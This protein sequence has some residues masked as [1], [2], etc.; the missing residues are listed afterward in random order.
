MNDAGS[1][2][3]C[4]SPAPHGFDSGTVPDECTVWEWVDVQYD[5]A[6]IPEVSEGTR[7]DLTTDDVVSRPCSP[8]EA[9]DSAEAD[10][11]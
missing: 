4:G 1:Q 5:D 7:Y 9:T 2:S 11:R 8:G 3:S 10:D 6:R